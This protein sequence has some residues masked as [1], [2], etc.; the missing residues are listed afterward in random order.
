M[1]IRNVYRPKRMVVRTL[2]MVAALAVSTAAQ[3]TKT[4][5]AL[6]TNTPSPATYDE[7]KQLLKNRYDQKIVLAAVEG[8]YAGEQRKADFNLGP[9]ANGIYWSHFAANMQ[10]PD[11]IGSAFLGGKKTSDLSQLDEHTFGDLKRGLNLSP[12]QRG[13]PLKVY[14]FYVYPDYIAFVLS[15]KGLEHWRDLDYGKASKEVTTSVSGNQV[16]R[17]VSVGGFGLVLVFYFNKGVIKDDR[18]IAGVLKEINKYLLPESEA[19][20]LA[21]VGKNIEIEP[22]MTE[23]QVTQKLGQPLQSVKFGDQKSLKYK[24]MTVV[25]KD[26]KVVDVKVE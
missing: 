10:V 13:E 20:A 19:Q 9:G 22:G 23:E 1:R 5:P 11:R 7:L 17:T 25:L 6:Q 8:L 14:K 4:P 3:D 12:I 2:A 16:N 24:G 15:T 21:N 18:D 26:G